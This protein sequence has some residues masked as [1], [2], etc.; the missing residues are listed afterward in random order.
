MTVSFKNTDIPLAP[1]IYFIIRR[2]MDCYCA[3]GDKSNLI[4]I[5]LETRA[6]TE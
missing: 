1:R 5:S 4:R 2:N 3:S 6:S